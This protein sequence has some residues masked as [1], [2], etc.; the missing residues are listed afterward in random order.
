[1]P[2]TSQP[3][4]VVHLIPGIVVPAAFAVLTGQPWARV[5]DA[6][7]VFLNA[8]GQLAF[9]AALPLRSVVII[10]MGVLVIYG[11]VVHGEEVETA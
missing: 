6:A 10:A 4:G 7:V 8:L 11:L 3:W 9:I 5:L 1:L 2:S